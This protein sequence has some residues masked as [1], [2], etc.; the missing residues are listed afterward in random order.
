[1]K[2]RKNKKLKFNRNSKNKNNIK[3][4]QTK[5]KNG[6]SNNK[7]QSNM[8]S[9]SEGETFQKYVSLKET[10]DTLSAAAD[11]NSSQLFSTDPNHLFSFYLK[12]NLRDII[13]DVNENQDY[14]VV[15]LYRMNES[16]EFEKI[17]HKSR[18]NAPHTKRFIK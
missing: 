4:N 6:G 17:N 16:N 14:N 11:T 8:N 7:I 18:K 2:S 10:H 9:G 12:K 13:V 15:N 5:Y 3:I 1:M